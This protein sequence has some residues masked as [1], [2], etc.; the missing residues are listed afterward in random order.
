MNVLALL[1]TGKS[2]PSSDVQI[3]ERELHE[4]IRQRGHGADNDG[5]TLKKL[6]KYV[7]LND[8]GTVDMG[9][10]TKAIDMI[11]CNW[12]EDQVKAVFNRFDKDGSGTLD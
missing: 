2:G 8:N 5:K 1:G 12:K 10:F 9:E 11:G 3:L 4:K 6:F 7:D